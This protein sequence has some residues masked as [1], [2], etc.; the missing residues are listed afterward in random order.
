[1][2]N[3]RT[4]LSGEVFAPLLERLISPQNYRSFNALDTNKTKIRLSLL[5]FG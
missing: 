2:L 4:V 5:A 3:L 1:M